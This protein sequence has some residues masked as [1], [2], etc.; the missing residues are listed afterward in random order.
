MPEND[1]IFS[2]AVVTKFSHDLAGVISAISNSLSLLDELGGADP[3]T[4][5]LAEENANI[6]MGRLRFFRAA[7][8]N[9]G[10]L[11]NIS[12]TQRIFENYLTTLENRAVHYACEWQTDQELPI[13]VFRMILLAGLIGAESLPRGGRITVQAQAGSRKISVFAEGKSA[14]LDPLTQSVLEK[15]ELDQS[16]SPKA[17][18]AVFLYHCL[19]EQ[20]WQISLFCRDEKIIIELGEKR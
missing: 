13:F 15:H 18:A 4:L 6:L 5:K 19:N 3:E 8:G 11:T 1:F 10:P 16:S 7:F 17:V 9:E 14:V 12:E 2:K 20:G